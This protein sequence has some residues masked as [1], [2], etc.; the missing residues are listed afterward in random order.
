LSL[1]LLSCKTERACFNELPGFVPATNCSSHIYVIG[2][3]SQA[4]SSLLVTR[5]N[6]QDSLLTHIGLAFL[7]RGR[8]QVF[9]ATD[10]A[11]NQHRSVQC[12]GLFDFFHLPDIYYSVLWRR[13]ITRHAYKKALRICRSFTRR[14]IFFDVDFKLGNGN[15]LYC[16]EFSAE[17]FNASGI[18]KQPF[19]PIHKNIDEP[20]VRAY[21][22]SDTLLYYP[23][24]FFQEDSLFR[25]VFEARK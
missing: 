19:Y 6:Q 17:V 11:R 4:K 25:K 2:R 21:L 24:D 10:L 15:K 23:V 9:H 18:N 14:N 22:E 7:V 3:G 16:S 13:E 5:F 1:L 20:L 12:D 8:W